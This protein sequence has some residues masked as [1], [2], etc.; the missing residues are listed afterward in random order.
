MNVTQLK[1][2]NDYLETI[3]IFQLIFITMTLSSPKESPQLSERKTN[4]LWVG[5][6]FMDI[7]TN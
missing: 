2:L 7:Q 1:D 3:N 6:D 4:I 5:K